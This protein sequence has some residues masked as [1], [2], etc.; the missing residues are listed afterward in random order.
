VLEESE[1][2]S[3]PED[4]LERIMAVTDAALGLLGVDEL[5]AELLDRTVELLDADTAAILLVDA[6]G[7]E[8]IARGARGIEEEV[9]QGVRVPIGQGFAGR[10]AAE[11]EPVIIDHVDETTVANPILWQKG[12]KAML[13]VPLVSGGELVGVLHVGTLGERHFAEPDIELLQL[14][15]ERV[16]TA[17]RMRL[18]E[19]RRDAAEALQRSLLPSAPPNLA[20]IEVA[21][22]Y[23]PAKRGGIGG[24]WYD[25]FRLEDGNVWIVT[26][27]VAGHG[28]QA[29]V[30]MG[31]VRSALRAYALL[32]A[33]PDE[34]LG[35]VDRKMQ[36]FEVGQ[37][38]TVA[39]AV[40]SPPYDAV[41]IAV[42]GHPPAVL[43][44]PGE[45]AELVTGPIGP[46][47]GAG[48]V[49]SWPLTVVPFE[50][51]AVLVFYTDG[52]IERR[53]ETIDYGLERV[54][55]IVA[56]DRPEVVCQQVMAGL[57]GA[58]EPD[59]DIAVLVARRSE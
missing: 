10:V 24:D 11:L 47:V 13:G 27:D 31:R 34:V 45:P 49:E 48:L 8:L 37:M 23:V 50:R 54:R 32:G 42:A 19:G 58:H 29:A 46:P 16:A 7:R 28:L 52:L 3:G 20:G 39:A 1:R 53:G 14:V 12:I 44:V 25:V 57:V 36:F 51:G 2:A 56:A 21:T 6:S 15:A 4:R 41:R 9:L 33:G 55:S 43:A 38:A 17:V 40:L 30:V 22:R 18:L 35:Q 5:L 26:G 59:D